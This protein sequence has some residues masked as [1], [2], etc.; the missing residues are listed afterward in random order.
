LDLEPQGQ[1]DA[2]AVQQGAGAPLGQFVLALLGAR[3]HLFLLSRAL[4]IPKRLGE[5]D[6]D[7]LRGPVRYKHH[8]VGGHANQVQKFNSIHYFLLHG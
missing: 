6:T 8:I 1:G 5:P 3:N 7:H 4:I 2:E